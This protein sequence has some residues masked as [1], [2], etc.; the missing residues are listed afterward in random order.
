MKR[1]GMGRLRA[2]I[3]EIVEETI[4]MNE[5]SKYPKQSKLRSAL[6]RL[7]GMPGGTTT[8]M[9]QAKLAKYANRRG[10]L[11]F[12]DD[13]A[14]GWKKIGDK[15][16]VAHD[17]AE[18]RP[19]GT[20]AHH[21]PK[22]LDASVMFDRMEKQWMFDLADKKTKKNVVHGMMPTEETAK[23]IA[24]ALVTSE[25]PVAPFNNNQEY[26]NYWKKVYKI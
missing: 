18:L 13:V 26:T 5:S 17:L 4:E 16:F 10:T 23:A 8:R 12:G 2:M 24:S 9:K 20:L 14:D 25:T 21:Y 7:S 6:G 15:Q 11:K 19:H 3:K 1:M 22:G